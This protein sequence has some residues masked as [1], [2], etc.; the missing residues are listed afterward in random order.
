MKKKIKVLLLLSESW[1]DKIYPNNNLTNWFADFE[2]IEI[3]TISGSSIL[4]DNQCCKEY[5]LISETDMIKSFFSSVKAGKKYTLT[6]KET[7]EKNHIDK[8]ENK[9]V[10]QKFSG[11]I[12]RLFRDIVWRYGKYN[13][14]ELNNFIC[15]FNPDI[16]FSQ[17]MGSVKMCRL[18]KTVMSVT[19]SPFVMYSGDDE[20]SLQQL[21]FS[22]IYWI[23]RF[24]TR[25]WLKKTVPYCKLFYSMSKRQMEEYKNKF[26]V[27][28][29]FLVKCGIFNEQKVHKKVFTPIR[30]IYA[31]KLY[32]N[33]WKTLKLIADS[34]KKINEENKK[35]LIQLNIYTG[36][37]ITQR[38]NKFLNDNKNSFI[39]DK[40]SANKLTELYNFSDIVLHV[41]SFDMKNKL[42]TKDSFSTKVID[43]M[44]S[45]CA[46]MAVCWEK[47]SAFK[48]LAENDITLTASS[49]KEINILLN[50]IINKPDMISE[51]SKKVFEFGKIHHNKLKIQTDIYNDFTEIINKC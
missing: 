51:Y 8:S 29:K 13:L 19:D 15:E 21:S 26:N 14:E 24:W 39:H 42:L 6:Y 12:A 32:C 18:E 33:R 37:K 10:K 22:L 7:K 47:Q 44:S 36:D 28:T 2:N 20:F 9:Y 25:N 17:R 48:Y 5:F 27:K 50:K 41:E 1:N 3:R 34:I 23:R 46:I 40:V 45:G 4:P 43:C 30:I 49:E 38:Q 11:E 16:V 31:G 35:I